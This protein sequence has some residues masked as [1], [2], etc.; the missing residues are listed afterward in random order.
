MRSP[1]LALVLVGCA[2]PASES[3][4]PPST[5]ASSADLERRIAADLRW[6]PGDSEPVSRDI[7]RP[8][9]PARGASTPMQFATVIRNRCKTAA[10]LAIG[11]ADA[12][13]AAVAGETLSPGQAILVGLTSEDWVHLR[14]AAGNYYHGVQGSGGYIIITGDRTCDT[15]VALER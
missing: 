5:A 7:A 15:I 13:S 14:G 1:C 9:T 2:G 4:P 10:R 12:A 3:T 8:E 11:S 6:Q